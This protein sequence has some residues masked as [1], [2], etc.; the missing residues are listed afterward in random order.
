MALT[1]VTVDIAGVG[2]EA[3]Q[4]T[5][6]PSQTV[7]LSQSLQP[8]DYDFLNYADTNGTGANLRLKLA[9]VKLPN[10]MN[11]LVQFQKLIVDPVEYSAKTAKNVV[12][13]APTAAIVSLQETVADH[14]TRITDLETP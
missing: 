14:E 7:I 1:L 6:A 13:L 12:R 4:V 9:S 3:V 5:P 10:G 8:I 11:G 2:K